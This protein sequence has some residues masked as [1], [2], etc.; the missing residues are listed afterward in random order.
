MGGDKPKKS[1]RGR[2]QESQAD[3]LKDPYR[4]LPFRLHPPPY[5]AGLLQ[6]SRKMTQNPIF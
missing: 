5:P 4:P 1:D 3:D 2:N 6:Q